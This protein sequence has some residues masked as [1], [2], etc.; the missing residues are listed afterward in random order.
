MR[1]HSRVAA[2][3]SAA[4]LMAAG[5]TLATAP[6]AAAVSIPSK[7]QY[8]WNTPHNAKTT[9][10]VNLRTGPSIS[11]TSLGLLTKGTG[12]THYCLAYP[13]GTNWAWGKVTSG[14]NKGKTGWV[15]YAYLTN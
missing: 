2:V 7:C 12:F 1:L 8:Q 13:N 5:A 6:T 11:Y 3:A 15:A 14:A 4:V 9:T 10:G